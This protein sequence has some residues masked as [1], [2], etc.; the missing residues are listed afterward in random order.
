M[1]RF[2]C[3]V[4]PVNPPVPHVGCSLEAQT[5]LLHLQFA[6]R[7]NLY[8]RNQHV[9]MIRAKKSSARSPIPSHFAL[10]L[11]LLSARHPPSQRIHLQIHF[12]RRECDVGS[13]RNVASCKM[14]TEINQITDGYV[15]AHKCLGPRRTSFSSIYGTQRLGIFSKLLRTLRFRYEK[16]NHWSQIDGRISRRVHY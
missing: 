4:S 5:L 7:V 2:G 13:L 9:H 1:Q 15:A 3:I 10:S 8:L 11:R 16:L 6:E 12:N 14:K